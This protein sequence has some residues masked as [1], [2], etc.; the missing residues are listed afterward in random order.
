MGAQPRSISHD[1]VF[2]LLHIQLD[3]IVVQGFQDVETGFVF[4]LVDEEGQ[5]LLLPDCLR[6]DFCDRFLLL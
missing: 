1:M 3:T 5:G 2:D 4:G 6:L